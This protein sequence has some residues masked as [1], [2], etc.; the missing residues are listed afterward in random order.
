MSNITTPETKRTR[1]KQKLWFDPKNPPKTPLYVGQRIPIYIVP[2]D[3][4][5]D[6]RLVEDT[7]VK[8]DWVFRIVGIRRVEIEDENGKKYEDD[9]VDVEWPN[10]HIDTD[11]PITNMYGHFA[12]IPKSLVP[13]FTEEYHSEDEDDIIDLSEAQTNQEKLMQLLKILEF[14]SEQREKLKKDDDEP[15][16]VVEETTDE[17]TILDEKSSVNDV[18]VKEH[19]ADEESKQEEPFSNDNVLDPE[20]LQKLLPDLSPLT[21]AALC[22]AANKTRSPEEPSSDS[23]AEVSPSPSDGK[24]EVSPPPAKSE[25]K[26]K[27]STKAKSEPKPK[28]SAKAKSEPKP[29]ASTKAKSEPKPKASTKAKSEPKP[30]ASTKAKSEPKPK[31]STKAKS[32]PKMDKVT[33]DDITKWFAMPAKGG[34]RIAELRKKAAGMGINNPQKLKRT[35]LESAMMKLIK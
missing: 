27:A 32:E 31:A 7:W 35:E 12:R 22:A 13:H 11:I 17:P 9:V 28:A 16:V 29:K 6:D 21:I 15:S 23:K 25:P 2:D 20:Q 26:P 1:P 3:T 5:E 4:E 18:I 14:L 19:T 30:K 8:T 24:S 10:G 33:M 34:L